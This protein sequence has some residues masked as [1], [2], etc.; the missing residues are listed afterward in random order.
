MILT[1]IISFFVTVV[2]GFFVNFLWH[3]Y[4]HRNKHKIIETIVKNKDKISQ[5]APK[6]ITN[7][8]PF[9]ITEQLNN[10]PPMQ[11]DNV[12][13]N[14]KGIN[15]SWRLNLENAHETSSGLTRLML[16]NNGIYPWVFCD[17]ELDKYPQFKII[18][19]NELFT[20]KGEIESVEGGTITLKNCKFKFN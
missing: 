16:L 14:Y 7:I 18:N 4:T 5:A 20:V 6:N 12:A 19:K 9:D 11:V 3:K 17:I 1:I 15:V 8:S 10:T 2:G 13:K